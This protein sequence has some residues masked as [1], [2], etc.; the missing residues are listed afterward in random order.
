MG[1]LEAERS[2]LGASIISESACDDALSML[3]QDDFATPEHQ[4]VFKAIS[5]MVARG[6]AI[7]CLTLTQSL[8][9]YGRLD[10]AGGAAYIAKLGSAVLTARH[11]GSYAKIVRDD[12]VR[13]RIVKAAQQIA[14]SGSGEVKDIE[15]YAD[16]SERLML[17][18]AE[19]RESSSRDIKEV[20]KDTMGRLENAH[21]HQGLTGIGSGF[22]DLDRML[23]GFQQST[24]Y[25]LAA[26]PSCGKTALAADFTRAAALKYG[27]P[28]LFASMEQPD[29][30]VGCRLIGAEGCVDTKALARGE[31]STAAWSRLGI[32][33]QRVSDSGIIID[34]ESIVSI[35]QL[36]A[37]ARRKHR[38]DGIKMLV[39][40]YIQL[41][42]GD[43]SEGREKEIAGIAR[44]LKQIARGLD[45][46]V[47]ALSQLNRSLESRSDKRPML[48]DLRE[49]GGIE[50]DADV[51]LFLYRESYYKPDEIDNGKTE[52]IIGKNR[53]GPI[54]MVPLTF[55]REFA[56]FS[57]ASWRD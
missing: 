10:A 22:Q 12:A 28:V 39:V 21:K 31:M 8:R 40:D 46:P 29:H 54:G 16:A 27:S 43:T 25:V 32:A 55:R 33:A 13:R 45:I 23:G 19:I 2:V 56:S 6:E 36:R 5:D 3:S 20:L 34:D 37:N 26:R 47:I 4:V 15:A 51:V 35:S 7:E 14:L 53:N 49:S 17:S 30:E 38:K 50:Q 9:K 48:S 41:M 11:V 52:L 57:S 24:L 42:S 18:A 44:G 1:L